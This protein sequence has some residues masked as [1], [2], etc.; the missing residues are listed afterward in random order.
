MTRQTRIYFE[1][2]PPRQT[3]PMGSTKNEQIAAKL[4]KRPGDW[5]K[6]GTYGSAS[7]MN[8]VAHQIRH[9]K[10]TP[11]TPEGSFEAVARTVGGKHNVW[12][13]YVGE[14]GEHA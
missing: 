12:A 8:S 6:I 14:G 4:R 10:L 9:G 11:Y 13:R 7:S 1:E 5:A 2:P 3:R